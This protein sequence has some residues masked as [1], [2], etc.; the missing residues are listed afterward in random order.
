MSNKEILFEDDHIQVIYVKEPSEDIVITFST[1]TKFADGS[2]VFA[3][4]PL[5]NLGYSIIGFVAKR[6]N[7][8]PHSSVE[9][10]FGKIYSI[11]DNYRTIIGYG[12][13]MGGYAVL[14]YS[15]SLRMSKA[16]SFIPQYS[17]NPKVIKDERYNSY[18]KE[19]I[20][21]DM[22]I[23]TNDI[24]SSC[25][26]QLVFDPY[27]GLDTQHIN[28]IKP[29]LSD[30]II[31]RLK[32]S[33]HGAA[34]ILAGSNLLNSFLS[35]ELDNVHYN[36]LVRQHKKENIFY[37]NYLFDKYYKRHPLLFYKLFNGISDANKSKLNSNIYKNLINSLILNGFDINSIFSKRSF[38]S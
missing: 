15:K 14:K 7:W 22:E 31:T 26:Y 29:L 1:L 36:K 24:S 38:S 37:F 16:I 11:I 33:G 4:R 17:I 3:E 20:N 27:F 2:Y 30:V 19:D 6:G 35:N 21:Q 9:L 28:M 10:S 34:Y 25:K 13:S 8:Y 12:G 32:F 23:T 18:Y 5:V